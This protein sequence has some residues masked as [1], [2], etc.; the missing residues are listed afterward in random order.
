M[1]GDFALAVK[2]KSS[3]N[4]LR[5]DAAVLNANTRFMISLAD[6]L[7]MSVSVVSNGCHSSSSLN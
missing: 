4:Y 6:G 5:V 3:I 2:A 7:T 1:G